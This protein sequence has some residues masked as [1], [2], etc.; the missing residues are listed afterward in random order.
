MVDNTS[1]A[2]ALLRGD[3][4]REQLKKTEGGSISVE[5]AGVWLGGISKQAVLD[6]YSKNKLLGW[7]EPPSNELRLPVWQFTQ[8][9]ALEG[10]EDVLDVLGKRGDWTLILFFLNKRSSLGN[11]RPLDALRAGEMMEVRRA[12]CGYSER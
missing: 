12:A 11:R 6:R 2:D 8:G 3:K 10:L 9:G 1:L 5:Q 7:K 4:V